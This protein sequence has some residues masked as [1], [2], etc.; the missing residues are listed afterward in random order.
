MQIVHLKKRNDDFI[1]SEMEIDLHIGQ[2]VQDVDCEYHV[3]NLD[4]NEQVSRTVNLLDV[5]NIN[6][7]V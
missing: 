7:L 2:N 6:H 5:K 3:C 1:F 4:W